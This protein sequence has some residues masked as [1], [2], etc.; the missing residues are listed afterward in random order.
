MT[1]E[2]LE[3]TDSRMPAAARSRP[4]GAIHVARLDVWLA[5]GIVVSDQITKAIVRAAIPVHDSIPI[6]PGLLTF[7]H[8][9]NTGAAFGFLNAADFPFKSVVITAIA[10]GALVAIAIYALRLAP[11]EKLARS[12]VALILGGA[13]GNLIDRAATGH[14]VDFVDVYW[15]S[16]HFWAFNVADA[17]I[18]IGAG[19]V[20]LDMLFAGRHVSTT[21]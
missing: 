4:T 9:Q 12:G 13:V 2:P 18:T 17:A 10:I 3:Y 19:L 8:V 20:I 5:A 1:P 21:V 14:V 15:R 16:Y 6:I 11:H 7:T